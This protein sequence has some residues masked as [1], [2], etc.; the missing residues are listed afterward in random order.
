[1][2]LNFS[3]VNIILFVNINY[4]TLS[5]IISKNS[6]SIRIDYNYDMDLYTYF[7]NVLKYCSPISTFV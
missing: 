6:Y 1:M 2:V 4:H 3:V 5:F 7:F